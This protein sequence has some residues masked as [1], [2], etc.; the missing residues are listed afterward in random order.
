MNGQDAQERGRRQPQDKGKDPAAG[1]QGQGAA[2]HAFQVELHSR[3][4]E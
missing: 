1:R 4:E 3:H 2:P